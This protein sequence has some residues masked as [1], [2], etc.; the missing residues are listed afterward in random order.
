[1]RTGAERRRTCEAAGRRSSATT[2][3][4]AD[5]HS[6]LLAG[7]ERTRRRRA[8]RPA[9]GRAASRRELEALQQATYAR[10]RA[11]AGRGG[12]AGAADVERRRRRAGRRRG[13]G[14]GWRRRS[15]RCRITRSLRR[16]SAATAAVAAGSFREPIRSAGRDE[17]GVLARSF[18]AMAAR[19]RQHDEMKE[20]FFAT[21]SHELRSPLTSV[22]EAAH[23]LRRRRAR[24]RSR[25]SRRGWSR[26]SGARPTG[27][28]GSSTRSSTSRGCA[29]G[30]CRSAAG[31]STS[32]ALVA[33]ALDELRPQADEAGVTLQRERVGTQ[34]AVIGDEDRLVQV[35]VNLLANAVRFTP[36]RRARRPCASWTRDRSARC[37]SRTPASASRPP[38]CR[39]SSSRTGRP[40][41]AGRHRARAG[42]RARPGAGARRP[43]HRRVAGGQGQPVHGAAAARWHADPRGQAAMRRA[44]A[45]LLLMAATARLRVP[46]RSPAAGAPLLARAD[47]LA[48]EGAWEEAV[49]A[50]DEYLTRYPDAAAAPRALASRDTLA[51][52]AGRARQELTRLRA[53]VDAAAGGAGPA[54]RRSHPPRGRPGAHPPGAGHAAGRGRP[55]A[56]R[57]RAPQ[58]DRPQTG[59]TPA[60]KR[61]VLVVDDDP[62][63]SRCSRCGSSP[64]AST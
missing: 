19:L 28:C 10:V 39:T 40:T 13:P 20:E 43:R 63:S 42:D 56:G 33:R 6:R 57:P 15:S 53:E 12:A 61:K 35:V 22:R 4:V 51:S 52:T 11:G 34:F 9:A 21:L 41:P 47:R 24:A 48:R 29:P 59:A 64:W 30:C 17:V 7:A 49:A 36:A 25:P 62:R 27:C 16:L 2:R 50:Y 1:M 31:R 45:V 32:S 37:R 60:M 26:S 44:L 46:G 5:E 18:N 58:A 8:G 23:L 14:A 38:S 55:A 54:A 3:A